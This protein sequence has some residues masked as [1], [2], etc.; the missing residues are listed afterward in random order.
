MTL[1][2]RVGQPCSASTI[3][4]SGDADW[5]TTTAIP[6]SSRSNT[7]G[8]QNEQF[9]DPMHA[10]RSMAISSPTPG[11]TTRVRV[12]I[13]GTGFGARVVAPA[14]AGAPGCEVV[15]VV[16]P[17]DRSAVE[18]LCRRT[19]VDLVS[20]HSPP[21]LHASHVDLAL[22]GG[23]HV[24]CDKPLGVDA[25]E[26]EQMLRAATAAGTVG[27]VNHEF[28][29]DPGRIALRDLV[30]D[31]AVGTPE[32]LVWTHLTAGA[33]RRRY[34]WLFDSSR[35]GGYVRA[36]GPHAVD[37]LRWTFGEID[38]ASAVRRIHVPERD[39][40]TCD[41]ED[42]FTASLRTESGVTATFEATFCAGADTAS[43]IVVSGSDGVLE[44]VGDTRLLC[45]RR[46]EATSE[47]PV[48]AVEGDP[49]VRPMRHYAEVVRDA[50]EAGRPPEGAPTFE[51][52]WACA[53]V[54][55][56]LRA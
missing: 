14:F 28:R 55:D 45:R 10:P 21:F 49:H 52:G 13:I 25:P 19:D 31:G 12:G 47:V 38:D 18:E 39:G 4:S 5:S 54:L 46:G 34:G 32:H 9:P 42:G 27:L 23:H 6:S 17:R 11:H 3:F 43:R 30:R 29:Y 37:F 53:L 48:P 7:P 8:A 56:R 35:G 36:W 44:L 33:R 1:I 26:S 16:S 15:D 24:L 50:V 20:I 40:E 22:A 51:D 2:A 41:A